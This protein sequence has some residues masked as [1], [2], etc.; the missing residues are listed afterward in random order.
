MKKL[1]W[2]DSRAIRTLRPPKEL[3]WKKLGPFPIKKLVVG[4]Y[5]YKI[6]SW[7][8]STAVGAQRE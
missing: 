2:L 8:N 7:G 3:D 5:A 4:P 6:E 1:V